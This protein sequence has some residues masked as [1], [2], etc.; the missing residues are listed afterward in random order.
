MTQPLLTD[1][2]IVR[3]FE[4]DDLD[5]LAGW[6]LDPEVNKWLLLNVETVD[7]VR[8]RTEMYFRQQAQLGYSFWA[9]QRKS[10]DEVIGGCGLL[11][12]GWAGPGGRARLS[13]AP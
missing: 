8:P 3:P 7:D 13:P 1:R 2:L 5:A 10:D 11:P 12:I 4:F 6:L 9:V